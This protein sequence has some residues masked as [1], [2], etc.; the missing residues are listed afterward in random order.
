MQS[1]GSIV[2]APEEATLMSLGATV[3]LTATVLDGNGQ[4]VE[5]AVV[6]WQSSDESVATVSVQG[7]VTAVTNGVVR[8]TATSGSASRASTLR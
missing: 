1:A 4:P 6:T 3:Q 7:L 8:I 5:G 2:I